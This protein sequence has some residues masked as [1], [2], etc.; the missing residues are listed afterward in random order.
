MSEPS[1]SSCLWF[2]NQAEEAARFYCSLFE[3]SEITDIFRQGG[4]PDA[5]AFTVEFSLCGQR[6]W[7]LNGGP[8]YKLTPAVSI[9][10]HI[11]TQA[12][13]DA[14]WAAL[15]SGGGT[16]SRCGWLTDRFGLSWQII[17]RALPRLLKS[18]R[19]GRVM[20]A[21]MGMVKLEIAALE[22]AAIG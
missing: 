16:E 19:T 21:M 6:F 10:V 8:H 11:D 1:V 22:K 17:P 9:T 20:E 12:E 2:D 7:A 3:G 13:I 18:D 4:D 15:L 14:L 5:A